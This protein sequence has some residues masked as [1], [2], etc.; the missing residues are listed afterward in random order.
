MITNFGGGRGRGRARENSND[1]V[2]RNLGIEKEK[3]K[4]ELKVRGTTKQPQEEGEY[5][6]DQKEGMN[7]RGA[8]L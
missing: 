8:Y 6:L 3:E 7:I 4:E 2:R 5:W 1:T